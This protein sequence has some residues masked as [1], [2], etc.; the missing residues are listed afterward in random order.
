MDDEIFQK[1]L[2]HNI[3]LRRIAKAKRPKIGIGNQ[4]R[5]HQKKLEISESSQPCK[6]VPFISKLAKI[7]C[8]FSWKINSVHLG[9][10]YCKMSDSNED[11]FQ[12]KQ[13]WLFWAR[14]VIHN[15]CDWNLWKSTHL[16]CRLVVTAWMNMDILEWMIEGMNRQTIKQTN[17][18]TNEKTNGWMNERMWMNKWT[19]KQAN[20]WTSE[21]IN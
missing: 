7:R 1:A 21:W 3:S 16:T 6:E 14:S 5:V 19:N 13:L 17:K 8:W 10:L 9:S 12:K 11:L 2:W 4:D 18:Q 20:K 15:R